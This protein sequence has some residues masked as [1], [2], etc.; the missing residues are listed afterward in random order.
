CLYSFCAYVTW[1][2]FG[3]K[4]LD[5]IELELGRLLRSE[6]FNPAQNLKKEEPKGSQESP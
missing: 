5:V 1:V 3:R 4:N 6:I 2:T